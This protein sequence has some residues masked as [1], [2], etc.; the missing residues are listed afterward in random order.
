MIEERR[1][2][3]RV[4]RLQDVMDELLEKDDSDEVCD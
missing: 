2:D 4:V 3:P 1:K